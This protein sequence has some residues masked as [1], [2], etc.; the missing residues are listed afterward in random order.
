MISK[1]G[2]V[3]GTYPEMEDLFAQQARELD[4]K[5]REALLH[6]IQ[7][8]AHDK[9]MF[10]PIFEL[11]LLVGVGPRLEEPALGLVDHFPTPAP[12]EEVRLKRR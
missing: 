8:V 7:R 4:R 2:F 6:Q 1:T 5:K 10:A 3:Y 11:A 9:V 12:W